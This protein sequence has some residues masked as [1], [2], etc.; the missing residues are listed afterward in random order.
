MLGELIGEEKGKVTAFKVLEI[1]ASGPK[2]E[3][4]A[5]TNGK[6]LGI[7]MMNNIS[8][9]SAM[10]PG[11]SLYGEGQGFAAT[12]DGDMVSW[13]GQGTG[14]LKQGGGASYRGAIH[15]R[16]GTGK[17]AR[18]NGTCAVFEHETDANDEVTTKYWEWK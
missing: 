14:R 13:L 4:S 10:Q 15:Y 16:N 1:T 9:W 6:I 5:R 12:R 7:D 17:L 18:L 3:V 11:G 2:V 8:Y